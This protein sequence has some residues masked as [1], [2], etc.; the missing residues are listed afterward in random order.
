MNWEGWA[1][2]IDCQVAFMAVA[3]VHCDDGRYATLTLH[4]GHGMQSMPIAKRLAVTGGA[5]TLRA[6]GWEDE[7]PCTAVGVELPVGRFPSPNLM[8]TAGVIGAAL[9][10]EG[11]P[12]E[13]LSPSAWKKAIGIG[14]NASKSFVAEWATAH[15]LPCSDEHECDA[16]GIAYA[17]VLGLGSSPTLKPGG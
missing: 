7:W 2:G 17:R 10:A 15:G 4:F 5:V 14:G 16:L 9:A 1:W 13:Y 12:V 3:F 8:M 11:R 6:H